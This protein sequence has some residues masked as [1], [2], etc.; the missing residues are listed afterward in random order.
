MISFSV[1]QQV[2]NKIPTVIFKNS[3]ARIDQVL[4]IKKADV[5]IAIV[6]DKAIRSLN[7]T[8]RGLDKVTD[9]LSFGKDKRQN[10]FDFTPKEYLGEII[11]CRLQAEK[12]AKIAKHSLNSEITLLLTHGF[13]HLLGYDHEKNIKEAVKMEKLEEKIINQKK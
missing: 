3:L 12:Q 11:I 1:N 9:V 10:K 4:K 5:S 2:K 7:K 8:Y 13:L 6:G